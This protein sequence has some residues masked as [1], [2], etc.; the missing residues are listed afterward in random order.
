MSAFLLMTIFPQTP[1]VAFLT[2]FQ[3]H[4][5]PVDRAAGWIMLVFLVSHLTRFSRIQKLCE[6]HLKPKTRVPPTMHGK[7]MHKIIDKL[8]DLP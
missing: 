2:F 7:A 5:F 4:I 1:C 6:A 3:E 8:M